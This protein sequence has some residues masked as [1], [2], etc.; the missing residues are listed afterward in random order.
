MIGNEVSGIILEVGSKVKKFKIGDC[1]FGKTASTF[2]TTGTAEFARLN[3]NQC[4][5]KPQNISFSEASTIAVSCET[6]FN[7]FKKSNLNTKSK[8]LIYGASGG[9]GLFLL[10]LVKSNHNFVTAVC[11]TR[12]ID[13]VKSFNVDEVLDYKKEDISLLKS[14]YDIIFIVNGYQ[15]LDKYLSLLNQQGKLV[16]VGNYKQLISAIFRSLFDRRYTFILG[17]GILPNKYN[18]FKKIPSIINQGKL[19]PFVEREFSIYNIKEALDYGITSHPKGKLVI[20]ID[21]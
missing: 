19:N 8:V 16:C 20:N 17:T 21:F 11:S 13:L 1:V 12:N 14:D 7:A 5:L 18:F 15:K 9:V 2:R 3:E 4:G 6:A 10:Q